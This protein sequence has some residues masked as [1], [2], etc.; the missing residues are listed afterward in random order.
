ML[1]AGEVK[2]DPK[3]IKAVLRLNAKFGIYHTMDMLTDEDGLI[4]KC[5]D[6]REKALVLDSIA[7]LNKNRHK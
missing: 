4:E 6:K 1:A 2:A 5:M 7:L 3:L